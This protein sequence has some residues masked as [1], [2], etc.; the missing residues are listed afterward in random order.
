MV[1]ICFAG[2][3]TIKGIIL[4]I[5]TNEEISNVNVFLEDLTL[6]TISDEDGYFKLI[7]PDE[8]NSPVIF[9]HIAFDTL[10]I[11][12][13]DA[14][15]TYAFY[16]KPLIS[17]SKK[18]I[19]Q[20]KKGKSEIEI[21]LPQ[22]ITIIDAKEFEGAGYIDAGD[23]LRSQQGIQVDE[24]LS[25]KKTIS[26]RGGNADDVGVYYNGVKMN[27]AYDGIFD[28]S[29]INLEDVDQIEIIKGSNTVLFG[30]EAFSGII[31]IVPKVNKDYQAR[32]SQK[33]GSYNSGEW[34][35]MLNHNFYEK[36]YLSY[37]IKNSGSK[38]AYSS[39]DGFLQNRSSH[40]LANV[41]YNL[42]DDVKDVET[43]NFS[44][45]YMRSK[46]EYDN[47]KAVSGID[48]LN[49]LGSAQFKGDLAFL[50]SLKISVSMQ[51]LDNSRSFISNK[52]YVNQDLLNENFFFNLE[53]SFI[54][55]NYSFF[56]GYQN[57]NSKLKVREDSTGNRGLESGLLTRNKQAGI[58]IFKFETPT[59]DRNLN[60]EIN[61]SYRFDIVEN[62]QSDLIFRN[63]PVTISDNFNSN[64]KWDA[65]TIKFAS[66]LIGKQDDLKYTFF[67][68]VGQN[69]KFPSMLQQ[70]SIPEE[71]DMSNPHII[72]NLN[73]EKNNSTELGLELF[74]ENFP[75]K[76]INGWQLNI[77]YFNSLFENKF[78]MF[79]QFG[80]SYAFYDNF[81]NA[82]ISGL[83]YRFR[84]FYKN[85]YILEIANSHL[86][87]SEKAA[88]PFKSDQKYTVHIIYEHLDYSAKLNWF[89][90]NEQVAWVKVTDG[91]LGYVELPS[92]SNMDF[93][94]SKQFE[95]MELDYQLSATIR[96][97]FSDDTKIAG[98]A[99]RDRRYYLGV[100]I[101]Y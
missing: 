3:I 53:K 95:F 84:T 4:N 25:G 74:K 93:H 83:E 92:Y 35:L 29:L 39:N 30:S 40:H 52:D 101:E 36:M 87:I 15:N 60:A 55:E 61:L 43:Q 33:I 32:F 89:F 91:S 14:S 13:K 54:W 28:F 6:G 58:A 5:D 34:S 24:K 66:Q 99:L 11:S 41:I 45:M 72:A 23:F 81:P 9:Q 49:Q 57:E 16:L 100:S 62:K 88:F 20:A 77:N 27:N 71:I 48:D 42:G 97:I 64:N 10:K 86:T 47:N 37:N 73:P 44:L 63:T 75:L 96:N 2:N 65:Q 78:R 90:E 85:K 51:N 8:T 68:N 50:K 79:Y 31:N 19:V 17:E 94:L 59:G 82:K 67:L 22:A 76:D 80:S 7:V 69:V 38:R 1:S 12:A 21:D 56:T 70:L 26:L 46:L 18:I 98:I